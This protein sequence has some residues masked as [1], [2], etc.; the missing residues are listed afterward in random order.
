MP[1]SSMG[2]LSDFERVIGLG[3]EVEGDATDRGFPRLTLQGGDRPRRK[4][5]VSRCAS[6]PR[7]IAY[8][9]RCHARAGFT[10][11]PALSR[12]LVPTQASPVGA[13]VLLGVGDGATGLAAGI[14]VATAESNG[15]GSRQQEITL[16]GLGWDR[17][18]AAITDGRSNDLFPLRQAARPLTT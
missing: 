15:Q 10:S 18:E 9:P 14:G 1:A 2:R 16:A 5:V 8:G 17:D 6:H 11:K 12:V 3:E 13:D 7:V 4:V